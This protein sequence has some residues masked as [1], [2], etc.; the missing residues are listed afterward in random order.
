M[1]VQVTMLDTR[2]GEDGQLWL[3]GQQYTA[4]ETFAQMLVSSNLAT[5]QFDQLP[6]SSFTVAEV[7]AARLGVAGFGASPAIQAHLTKYHTH[8]EVGPDGSTP[9]E[10]GAP[11]NMTHDLVANAPNGLIDPITSKSFAAFQTYV[12]QQLVPIAEAA[13]APYWTDPGQI[14]HNAN[15]NNIP[16]SYPGLID[17]VQYKGRWTLR[18]RSPAGYGDAAGNGKRRSQIRLP[19]LSNRATYHWRMSFEIPEDDEPCWDAATRYAFPILFWQIIGTAAGSQPLFSFML[20]TTQ[21]PNVFRL[22]A[23]FR[24]SGD[25]VTTT[26][27]YRRQNG[28]ST[29]TTAPNAD[30]YLCNVAVRRNVEQVLDIVI[31]LDERGD[32]DTVYGWAK[33]WL[34]GEKI[35]D[36]AGPTYY[37][38]G[39]AAATAD[40][41]SCTHCTLYRFGYS[42][43]AQLEG[44]N[45]TG[46]AELDLNSQTDPAPY[47]RVLHFYEWRMRRLA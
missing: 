46:F 3:V 47:T 13:S 37:L 25:S 42:R 43:M 27:L 18:L 24:W 1:P 16:S 44:G 20:E 7:Q 5:A 39:T 28:S 41:L 12:G 30:L 38:S 14:T 2:R 10:V 17:Y 29:G 19:P 33:A 22:L 8:S 34:N 4:S 6:Q 21:D 40:T 9:V 32:A 23:R 36:Y 11:A 35:V 31:S 26:P 45:P 15:A